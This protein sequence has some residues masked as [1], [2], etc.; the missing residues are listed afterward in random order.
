M[1]CGKP[2]SRSVLWLRRF[3]NTDTQA[4]WMRPVESQR[5][6]VNTVTCW[7]FINSHYFWTPLLSVIVPSTSGCSVNS[8][9]IAYLWSYTLQGRPDTQH[10]TFRLQAEMQASLSQ[11]INKPWLLGERPKARETPHKSLTKLKQCA[12][13][14]KHAIISDNVA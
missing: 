9:L 3:M 14:L 5:E 12:I 1:D 2:E 10:K 11:P 7:S 6:T 4:L 8:F 13:R